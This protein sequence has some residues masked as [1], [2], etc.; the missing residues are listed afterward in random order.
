M[1]LDKESIPF[2]DDPKYY[3]HV[4]IVPRLPLLYVTLAYTL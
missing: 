2:D 4:N 3:L 1:V